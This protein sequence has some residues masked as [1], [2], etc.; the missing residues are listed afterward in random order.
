MN[1]FTFGNEKFGYYET[2]AGGAGAGPG[3]DGES[4]VQ[5]HMTNTRITDPEVFEIRY[6]AIL[7]KFAIRVNSGGKGNFFLKKFKGKWNGGN[8]IEREYIFKEKLQ[9]SIL[10]ER[11]VYAPC[12][13]YGGENGR[14]G[15]N[16]FTYPDGR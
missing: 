11:R 7:N 5:V 15:L 4:G 13:L 9:V 2:I 8:G 12:G 16:L 3:F 10:S 14:R 6:P 1:N